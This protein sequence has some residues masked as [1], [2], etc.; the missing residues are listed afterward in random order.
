[1]NIANDILE[2]LFDYILPWFILFAIFIVI[3]FMAFSIYYAS[4]KP[5]FTL[6]KQE[7]HCSKNKTYTTTTMVLSGK[8]M[9]PLIQTIN[10]CVQW[11]HND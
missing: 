9:V 1:M 11:S 4:N 2:W 7:W 3:P 10:E 8:V 6:A 5:N